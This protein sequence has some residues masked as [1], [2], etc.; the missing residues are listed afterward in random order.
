M[1]E[2]TPE[3]NATQAALL[4]FLH[5]GPA[6][7]WEL[8]E[9][10]RRGLA[11]FWN[12]TS[13]HVYRELRTLEG[14][15]LARAGARGPR[16]RRPFS[17]TGPGRRAFARWIRE[18]P[19]HEQIRIPLLVTLWF[20]K[21]L[22]ASTLAQFVEHHRSD[23]ERRLTEYQAFAAGAGGDESIDPNVRA[24]V[25]FGIAYEE[26]FLGW[27]AGLPAARATAG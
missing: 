19:A 1:A 22:D 10:V 26:A 13:S 25:E 24:V 17:V 21:H 12:V 2:S 6:T 11:R 16:E 27:L 20:A 5:D 15:G 8:I 9:E 4:G 23:H 3:L 7:G 14:R 18:E